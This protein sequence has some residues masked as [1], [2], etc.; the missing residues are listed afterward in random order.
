MK[1][2]TV[3]APRAV[4]RCTDRTDH[5]LVQLEE[6]ALTAIASEVASPGHPEIVSGALVAYANHLRDRGALPEG[7]II[8]VKQ[9]LR[10][11]DLESLPPGVAALSRADWITRCIRAYFDEAGLVA[12]RAAVS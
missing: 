10:S 12:N 7:M 4:S 3:D 5:V 2:P 8:C 6:L 9:L 11:S 1:S